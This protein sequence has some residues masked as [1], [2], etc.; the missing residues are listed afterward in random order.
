VTKR[1]DDASWSGAGYASIQLGIEGQD[2]CRPYVL[3]S[4][5]GVDRQIDA[6]RA[7]PIGRL[8]QIAVTVSG[9]TGTATLYLD[10]RSVGTVAITTGMTWGPGTVRSWCLGANTTGSGVG[11]AQEWPGWL[12]RA[13]VWSRALSSAELLDDVRAVKG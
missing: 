11:Y 1:C 5:G 10:G 4:D 13:G 12:G 9:A 6:H 7:L 3:L 2:D 8:T